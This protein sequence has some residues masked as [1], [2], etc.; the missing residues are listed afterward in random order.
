MSAISGRNAEV[1][2][3]KFCILRFRNFHEFAYKPGLNDNMQLVDLV[4]VSSYSYACIH[5]VS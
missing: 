4:L 3:G 1:R 2:S 5:L